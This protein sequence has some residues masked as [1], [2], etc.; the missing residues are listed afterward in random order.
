MDLVCLGFF[1]FFVVVVIVV[2]WREGRRDME[3]MVFYTGAEG[4]AYDER[5]GCLP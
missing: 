1:W 5:T 4:L 2:A 3:T